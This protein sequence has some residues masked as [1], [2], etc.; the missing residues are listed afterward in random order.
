MSGMDDA[1]RQ[2]RR[3]RDKLLMED[4]AFKAGAPPLDSEGLP[5]WDGCEP[6]LVES[7]MRA[8][9]FEPDE[10]L[11]EAEA[12]ARERL[13]PFAEVFETLQRDEKARGEDVT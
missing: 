8:L 1:R 4:G 5:M 9:G 3:L 10:E 6:L 13:G 12:D 2:I 7:Y 11:S